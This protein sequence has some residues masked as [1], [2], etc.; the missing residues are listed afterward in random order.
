MLFQAHSM[1][2]FVIVQR[3]IYSTFVAFF[4]WKVSLLASDT[5]PNIVFNIGILDKMNATFAFHHLI[6]STNV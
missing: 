4:G 6:S 2:S 5:T 1:Q 3:L